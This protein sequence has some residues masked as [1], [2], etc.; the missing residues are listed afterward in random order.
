MKR[1]WFV[2]ALVVV[3]GVVFAVAVLAFLRS[4]LGEAVH[5]AERSVLVVDLEGTVVEKFPPD[6]FVASV[7]GARWQLVDLLAGIRGAADDDRIRGL[8]L[9]VGPPGYGWAK[10]EELRAALADFREAGKFVEAYLPPTDELGY[11]VALAADRIWLLPDGGLELNGFRVETPFIQRAFEKIGLEAQVESVGAYKSAA[12]MLR[13]TNMTDEDRE[14]TGGILRELHGRFVDAVVESRDVD[15]AAFSRA[16]EGGV[17]LARDLKALGLVDGELYDGQVRDRALRRAS[18]E[19]AP[20]AGGGGEGGG[21]GPAAGGDEPDGAGE[22]S[23]LAEADERLIRIEDYLTVL[24]R[25]T[26]A[27]G[28]TIALVYAVGTILPGEDVID[29]V[30]GR[31]M[32]AASAVEMLREVGRNEDVDA[33]V[34][35]VDSPGGDAWASE[36]IW[37]ELEELNERVPLVVSMSDVAGSGGYYIAAGADAIVASPS[38]ITGSIGVLGILFNAAG[39]YEKLGVTWD[40]LSTSEAADFPTTIRPLTDAERATFRAII[41]DLYRSFVARVAEGRER[42]VAQIDS[43]AGGRI[44]SGAQAARNGLVD[45][46]GGLHEAVDVAKQLGDIDAD[47]PVD[48]IVYPEESTLFERLLALASPRG[49]GLGALPRGRG[50][51]TSATVTGAGVLDRAAPGVAELARRLAAVGVA[52]RSEGPRPLAVMPFVPEFR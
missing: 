40:T 23:D 5:V 22:E 17:Y 21:D 36:E 3:V 28:G 15:R 26:S 49:S 35:R 11:Y 43:V 52:L 7:E 48:V 47:A 50:A 2:I 24:P 37:A 29:P 33:V 20:A 44:W 38:T 14:V 39:T 18:G 42:S 32:G 31:T 27:A 9:R 30:F 19:D 41:E 46:L 4:R 34:L 8:L 10:A 45:R 6:P 13:R 16:L 1:V 12:D 51:G 25:R